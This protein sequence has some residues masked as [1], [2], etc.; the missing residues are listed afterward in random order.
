MHLGDP[1]AQRVGDQLQRERPA[2]VE[3]VA[4]AGVVDVARRVVGQPVVGAVVDAAEGQHRAVRAALGR[5]VV[6]DVEDDLEA[7]RVQRPH[8]R[9][10]L[11][12]LVALAR[13]VGLVRGEEAERVVA[14]VVARAAAL[15]VRLGD[16]L[17]DRQQLDRGDA[18]RGQVLDGGR[19]GQP[20]VGAAQL[21]RDVGVQV[22]E[23]LDVQLVDDR[24][25]PRHPR[26]QVA[27]PG[28]RVVDDDRAGDERRR[29]LGVVRVDGAVLDE[30]A[31]DRPG[32]GVDQ[33]LGRV[34]EQPCATGRT[35]RRRGTRSAGP[36]RRRAGSRATRGRSTRPAGCASRARR[37]TGR[38]RPR[39][40]SSTRGRSWCRRRPSG[41]R[42]GTGCPARR[43]PAGRRARRSAA[44]ATPVGH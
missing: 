7:G 9:L 24:V 41:R 25:G 10:E 43:A 33:Q 37:R 16:E 31:L 18:E 6:D 13:R 32:I 14:P 36:G 26:R 20:G 34:V 23:A 17:V 28:E 5:V 2:R 39:W 19:V 8:H 42:A 35:G 3:G 38:P 15:Q 4:A 21:R 27:A 29:V 11:A 40:R 12:D 44:R 30:V 22:G 1:V